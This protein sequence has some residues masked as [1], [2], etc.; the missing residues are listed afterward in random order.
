MSIPLLSVRGL[1]M[2]FPIRAGVLQRTRGH[3]YA[4]SDV[5]FDLRRGGTLGIVGE[6]GSGKSTLGKCIIR[7]VEPTAGTVVF[8]GRDV[9]HL[10]EPE[11]RR[12]IRSRI[13]MVFQDPFSSLNP[14]QSLQ[15]IVEEPLHV[16]HRLERTQRTAY[17]ADLIERVG[18]DPARRDRKPHEFSGGQRQRIAI[19]RALALQ[20]E[21]IIADEPVSALDV[22]VQAQIMNLLEDLQSELGLTY[23]F[24]S[25]DLSVVRHASEDVA[26]MYLGRLMELAPRDSLFADYRH[27]YTQA[28][29]SAV[30]S[31]RRAGAQRRSRVVLSG[32]VPDSSDPPGGCVFHTRCPYARDRCR[33][34]VPAVRDIAENH[35]IACH[36]PVE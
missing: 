35:R 24:I 14:R 7:L 19:A 21:L 12:S 10:R 9:T 15:S 1:S 29:M 17:A 25:H 32:E 3:V 13:Q 27:P 33:T 8:D 5:S 28:L 11:L 22:S 20:P 26:V 34:E 31:V 6:S 4:V 23:V 30:P 36:F 2:T 16:H 18:L